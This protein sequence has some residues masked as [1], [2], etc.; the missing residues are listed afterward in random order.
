MQKSDSA[1]RSSGSVF[2]LNG[3]PP[4]G[5]MI[6]LGLQHVVAAIVGIITPAI[7]VANTCNLSDAD[8]TLLI[9]VSLIVTALAT[10]LQLYTINHKIGAGLPVVMGISFAY[11]PTL[12]AIGGQFDLPTILGAE[13]VG[14]CVA[15]LF[16]IFVK[17]IRRLFPPLI[18][19]TVI[20][21]IG[22]S[23]YPTA[24]RYMA[25]GSGAENFGGLKSWAVALVTLAVVIILQNFGKGVLKLGAILWGMIVGYILAL[26]LGM[27]DFSSVGPA[28]WFQLAAPLHFGVKF[29]VSACISLAVVYI[30]NA[31]QTIG[32]LSSTTMGG[33]DRMPT[34][35]ELSGGIIAQGVVSIVGAL[36]GGLPAASY[37]QNVG[38][39]TVNKV[40]NKAVFAFASLVLLVAGL[41][42]KLSA[43]LT[44]IPQAVIGG[45]T[46]SVFATITM[47]GIRM[48]TSEN[49]TMRSSAVV[50]L[51]VALGVGITQVSGS[52]QGP[53]FPIWV[54]TVFG[55]SPIVVTAVMAIILNLVLPKDKVVET[56][57][58]TNKR[59]SNRKKSR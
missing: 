46:I 54:N 31:V 48:I 16:G 10:L 33:M 12:L 56:K 18:T 8:R 41:V 22:L 55:S 14:G 15:I 3:I 24:V 9:Q 51:S 44:T 53:G 34:D 20:F 27:V 5:Q 2:S 32:D 45:A 49:F 50:G 59:K 42:P 25:G 58:K 40:I 17:Q 23:L 21:T 28:G 39:V 29:E 1:A 7:M 30:I 19:G 35:K 38:I 36:F 4:A 6:P 37:S 11:V 26:C 52:L 43:I 57:K 13:I 47:T